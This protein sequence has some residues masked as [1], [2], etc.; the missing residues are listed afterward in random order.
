MQILRYSTFYKIV[1][2]PAKERLSICDDLSTL[3]YETEEK[4]RMAYF[5]EGKNDIL[6]I[7][8]GLGD[9]YIR[10]HFPNT[11]ITDGYILKSRE[12]IFG[13]EYSPLE[14]QGMIIPR[15]LTHLKSNPQAIVDMRTGK[16]KTFT[17]MYLQHQLKVPMLVLVKTR[18]LGDQWLKAVKKNTKMKFHEYHFAEGSGELYKLARKNPKMIIA[19]HA[20]I[21]SFISKVGYQKMN[22]WLNLW[23]CGLKVYDEADLETGSMFSIDLHTSV[24]YMLYLTATMYKSNKHDQKVFKKSFQDVFQIGAEFYDDEE[25]NRDAIIV[26]WD[27]KPR[28]HAF[29]CNRYGKNQFDRHKYCDY[30]FMYRPDQMMDLINRVY[31]KYLVYKEFDDDKFVIYIASKDYCFILREWMSRQMDV[32]FKDIGIVN[33]LVEDKWRNYNMSRNIII[34]TRQSLSRG[35]DL[36]GI[37]VQLDLDVYASKSEF[38]QQ[39]GRTGRTGGAKGYY[40]G[41]FDVGFNY[42]N[43][44]LKGKSPFFG[45]HF[46]NIKQIYQDYGNLPNIG[47]VQELRSEFIRRNYKYLKDSD[48]FNKK[49]GKS[50]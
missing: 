26:R 1:N 28:N 32:H 16:G 49:R 34:T 11:P 29:L 43:Q 6:R 45:K 48:K 40:F 22:E 44:T 39:V 38:E 17:A 8:R 41:V 20:S 15:V 31:K 5:Y 18:A 46:N 14:K 36:D 25:Q 3:D 50:K 10:K 4:E 2:P 12:I 27:S 19:T 24:K 37:L 35:I 47:N 21:R 9:K 30:L 23:K 42:V 7:P 13:M 33:S